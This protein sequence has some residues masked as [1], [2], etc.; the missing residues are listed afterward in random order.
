V[1]MVFT[2]T[3]S[4]AR[5]TVQASEVLF[6][7]GLKSMF[8][9]DSQQP[10]EQRASVVAT[11]AWRQDSTGLYTFVPPPRNLAPP[12]GESSSPHGRG[13]DQT[14]RER[15]FRQVNLVCLLASLLYAACIILFHLTHNPIYAY[16][17]ACH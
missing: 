4:G 9:E 6:S 12:P 10:L 14:A 1:E 16:P 13:L 7:L 11:G 17:R 5:M 2:P 3:D 15:Q 8:I